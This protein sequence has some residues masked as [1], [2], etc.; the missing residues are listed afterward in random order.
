MRDR[1][2]T[3]LLIALLA[4]GSAQA[5][6]TPP[7]VIVVV[8][9][10][11]YPPYLFRAESGYLE[12]IIVDK[13]ALW[14]RKTGVRVSVVGLEWAKA[15]ETVQDGTADVIDAMAYTEARS[16]LYEFSSPYADVDASVFF[17]KSIKAVLSRL[18]LR[19]NQS[20][21]KQDDAIAS[22]LDSDRALL[23]RKIERR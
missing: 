19:L 16:K 18:P 20:V 7:D 2:A 22:T 4:A 14:S 9:D 5:A 21:R 13:W 12:G 17:N 6:F 10:D 8:S 1:A 3:A 15:Q 11:S 23:P